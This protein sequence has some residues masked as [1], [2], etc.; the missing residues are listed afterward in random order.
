[1]K[2][3]KWLPHHGG[4]VVSGSWDATLRFTDVRTPPHQPAMVVDVGQKVR[5]QTS[6]HSCVHTC[7]FNV[8]GAYSTNFTCCR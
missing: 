1:M 5:V 2:A 7:Y 4:L 6:A 8:L 3:V